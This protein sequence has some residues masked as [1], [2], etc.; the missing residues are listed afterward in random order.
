MNDLQQQLLAI[1]RD[2]AA[3]HLEEI[4]RA[5]AAARAG[6]VADFQD[7]FRR[8]HSLKGA[9]RAVGNAAIEALAHDLEALLAAE[10]EP[11]AAELE[12]AVR[13]MDSIEAAVSPTDEGSAAPSEDEG[14]EAPAAPSPDYLRVAAGQVERAQHSMESIAAELLHSAGIEEHLLR[15]QA[16]LRVMEQRARRPRAGQQGSPQELSQALRDVAAALRVQR[17]S[18]WKL[19]QAAER[20]RDD[21]GAL[22]LVPIET[23]FGGFGRMM[24]ELADERGVALE[25]RTEGFA[26]QAD[27]RVLQALRDPV[28]H[29]LRNAISHGTEPAAARTAQGKPPA[30]S[31]SAVAETR[32]GTLELVIRDDGKGL[33]FDAIAERA[34]QAGLVEPDAEPPREQLARLLF[35]AGFSTAGEV[36]RISGRGVGLAVV[37]D[38][39]RRL[40]GTVDIRPARP[41][42]T[43]VVI[44][45]PLMQARHHLLLVETG[46]NLFALP[47]HPIEQL[48]RLK[49]EQLQS[50]GGSVMAPA[51]IDGA[52]VLVPMVA[53]DGLIG[54]GGGDIP[55]ENGVAQA[56]LMRWGGYRCAL[57]V[58]RLVD[59][60]EAVV[61]EPDVLT[62]DPALVIGSILVDERP[63]LV[64]S[65]SEMLQRWGRSGRH[66]GAYDARLHERG[67]AAREKAIPTILVVDDSITTRTLEKSILEAQG[68]RVVLSVDGLDALTV[69]RN[70]GMI[71]LV[72]SDIE[73]PRM[74][75]FGLLQAM[76]NDRHL[77]GIPVILMTSR[78]DPDD[79]QRGIDL[80]AD[81]YILK[82]KFD[83]RELL[84]AIAQL[85]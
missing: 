57:A 19:E 55:L 62:S 80:G 26:R 14:A 22:S 68:Y 65:P 39:V 20:L 61:T 53:L 31:V 36:D 30:A 70:Q 42:G 3:E 23:V 59:A 6:A 25:F 18:T 17:Q 75:G 51:R 72:V 27:R 77:E 24:R 34:R 54:M 44:S 2:E 11:G 78:A 52:D 10:Q 38:A 82:Q 21:L 37:E 56:V 15:I 47:V 83:Q 63:V 49:A 41:W 84:A 9:A 29:L 5:V 33:D 73:M 43:E 64:L 74:D 28:M 12:A 66:A 58:D 71:D 13:L 4:R 1:F 50:M 45:V 60:R 81:A 8:A 16:G 85:L 35:S 76:K 40:Q 79:V 32:E 46:A 48:L 7:A 69:L 67:S